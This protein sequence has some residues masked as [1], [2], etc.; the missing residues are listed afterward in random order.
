MLSGAATWVGEHGALLG[1]R[2]QP[3]K[4]AWYAVQSITS[5]L[6][7]L[8]AVP[9]LALATLGAIR[10]PRLLALAGLVIG[11]QFI[12]LVL[13]IPV[14]DDRFLLSS[15]PALVLL[16]GLGFAGVSPRWRP[17][18]AGLTVLCGL[19]VAS[20][21]HLSFPPLP[22]A[23]W[24]A[25]PGQSWQGPPLRGHGIALGDSFERRG[26][27]RS[28]STPDN[29]GEVRETVWAELA[30]CRPTVVL[31]PEASPEAAPAGE[32]YWLDYRSMLASIRDRE[33]LVDFAERCEEPGDSDLALLAA[34]KEGDPQACVPG[35]WVEVA[36]V[37]ASEAW[38]VT[39][40]RPG[41]LGSCP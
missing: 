23:G 26:W 25:S 22:S 19:W 27:S 5:V 1:S 8:F 13:W 34:P 40:W 35:D 30:S 21:F 39:L 37:S 38:D 15:L 18:V 11:G 29:R 36:R 7:P 41:E 2:F 9:V 17:L 4:L 28:S 24:E 31:I 14:L 33:L 6:S 20:E 10:H 3:D 12:F 32:V 16:A